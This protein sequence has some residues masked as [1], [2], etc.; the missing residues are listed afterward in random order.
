MKNS[1]R[2]PHLL[3]VPILD[4]L[5]QSEKAGFLDQCALQFFTEATPLLCQGEG[6]DGIYIVADGT[7][8][9]SFLNP[10][11]DKSILFH[12]GRGHVLGMI[13]LLAERLCAANCTTFANT[14]V[15]YCPRA[16]WLE[17]MRSLIMVR[18]FAVYV[19]DILAAANKVKSVDQ[20][21]SVEQRI[22]ITL[23]QLCT[24]D[25]SFQHSQAYLANAVGCSRQTVNKE[26]GRLRDLGIIELSR[27]GLS[28]L[29]GDALQKRIDDLQQEPT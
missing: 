18:N 12:G 27:S 19:H 23:L 15:L 5:S 1:V 29:D 24:K 4:G 16:L 25:G 8:E 2:F 22:C 11:G 14:T 28:L 13:E 26:L 10:D 3:D 17:Q 6:A 7:V 20:F 21:Y 9:I